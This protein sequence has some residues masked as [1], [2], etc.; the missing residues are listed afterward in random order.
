[1]CRL[2]TV[3]ERISETENTP[4]E[5]RN[6]KIQRDKQNRTTKSYGT[7]SNSPTYVTGTLLEKEK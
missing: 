7:I 4:R 6:T 1:M 5:I 2:S 3:E